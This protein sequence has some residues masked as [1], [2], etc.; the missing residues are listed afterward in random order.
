MTTLYDVYDINDD[1]LNN[2]NL[3]MCTC[4]I[5]VWDQGP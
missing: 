3:W 4:S 1:L 5:L 2:D